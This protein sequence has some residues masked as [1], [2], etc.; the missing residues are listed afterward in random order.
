M[1]SSQRAALIKPSP[2]MNPTGEFG[3]PGGRATSPS[4]LGGKGGMRR[5]IIQPA[6]LPG[7][8]PRPPAGGARGEAAP[9]KG[10]WP[11]R[12]G[13]RPARQPGRRGS[14][15]GVA[16]MPPRPRGG[17]AAPAAPKAGRC[18]SPAVPAFGQRVPRYQTERRAG[19]ERA[20]EA[21]I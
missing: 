6:R 20:S 19:I 3:S 1:H 18:P 5:N 4:Y 16:A 7:A 2:R 17:P 12:P 11:P 15:R 21:E 9:G 10:P 14:V 13:P 8:A